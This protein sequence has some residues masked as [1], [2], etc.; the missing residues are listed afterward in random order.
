MKEVSA[1][2]AFQKMQEI[3][4][5]LTAYDFH[6]TKWVQVLHED[7]SFQNFES[8]FVLSF[9]PYRLV[10]TE[11]HG[12]HFYHR[13]DVK[14]RQFTLNPEN[15]KDATKFKPKRSIEK[16]KKETERVK[17]RIKKNKK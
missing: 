2:E 15:P 9:G 10:F 3:K 8:A 7:G 17:A 5:K 16:I 13:E 6:Y 1:I 11:H 4:G 12:D 14:I